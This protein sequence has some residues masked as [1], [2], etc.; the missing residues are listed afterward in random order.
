MKKNF[1]II[2]VIFGLLIGFQ[3]SF[4]KPCEL[5]IKNLTPKINEGSYCI[6]EDINTLL[7]SRYLELYINDEI[8]NW[9][10]DVEKRKIKIHIPSNISTGI[11][12]LKIWDILN[13]NCAETTFEYLGKRTFTSDSINPYD[14]DPNTN[15]G[16]EHDYSGEKNPV[17]KGKTVNNKSGGSS[18]NKVEDCDKFHVIDGVFTDSV[19]YGKT[20]EWSTI[21]P[22]IGTFSNLYLDYCSKTGILHIMNDWKLGNGNYD[23]LTCYNEFEFS[24]AGGRENWKIKIYNA[25][26]KGII[27]TLNGRDVSN[28]TNLVLGGR[29]GNDKSLLVDSNHT[30]WEFGV[31][32]SGGL[33]IMRIFRDEVGVLEI[34]P[35][36]RLI[37]DD[38][39]Y[40]TIPEPHIFTGYLGD[41]GSELTMS[42]RYIPLSGVAGLVTEP[43]SFG[44]YFSKD[45]A[46]IYS[47]KDNKKIV[48][49]CKDNH[50]I[51]GKFTNEPSAENEWKDSRPAEGMFSNLYAEFCKGKLYIL[52]DWKLGYEEPDKQNCYN[53]FELFT[54]NGKEHWGIFVYNDNTRKPTIF[55]NGVDV[56]NDT[57]IVENGK[58][59]FSTSP[60]V[61]FEH[62]IYEFS[63]NTMEGDWQLFLCDPGPSS[64]CDSDSKL[65]RKKS[66]TLQFKSNRSDQLE[67]KINAFYNDTLNLN[68]HFE[69]YE[70]L[71]GNKFKCQ[72]RY[73]NKLIYP[74]VKSILEKNRSNFDSLNVKKVE[75]GL[76]ELEG[77]SN[78][79]SFNSSKLLN[80][81]A[82][83]L[84][85]YSNKSILSGKLLIGNKVRY[86]REFDIKTI[87]IVAESDCPLTNSNVFDNM[88][89]I[90]DLYPNPSETEI[91]FNV[92]AKYESNLIFTII[93]NQGEQ[94]LDVKNQ[95][96]VNG[97]NDFNLNVNDLSPGI[98]ILKIGDGV[99]TSYSKFIKR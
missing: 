71:Y 44:G 12:T 4:S 76:I 30:M 19:G 45:S 56:S 90:I 95:K 48:N 31:K 23:S 67:N 43:H 40:G 72:I 38:N 54:G 89:S 46:I 26:T 9:I 20:K 3:T 34:K 53:L 74:L 24:T 49:V 33:F 55:R 69:D 61:D 28:D 78:T 22:L 80:F 87:E 2:F 50:R 98:Y 70:M 99:N 82:I 41:V 1:Y 35:S 37:C 59:G 64:F 91:N 97:I 15:L 51:D 63:I 42:E 13:E 65:P 73:D 6:V 92:L 83:V 66:E 93:N 77:Y 36:V 39:G 29:Y 10:Y 11:Y 88:L 58:Y 57:L 16:P 94:L 68:V 14:P 85:G 21:T 25:I 5:K 17:S 32:A 18:N 81:E 75:N 7:M 86:M 8:V 79:N 96:V 52:N 27:V 60:E 47:N 84:A 62:T